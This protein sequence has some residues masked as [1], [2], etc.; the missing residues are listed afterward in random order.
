LENAG[1]GTYTLISKLGFPKTYRGKIM[2]VAFLGTHAPLLGAALYLLLGSSVSL[3]AALRIL[4]LL[5]AVTLLGAAATLVVLGALLA[6]VR[7]TSS[8]LKHYLDDRTKPDLPIGFSDEAGRLMADARYAVEHL[9][10]SIRSLEGLSGTD[11][12]SGLP[13]RREGEG[14]LVA[15]IA[16]T[17]RDGGRLTVAVVDL[18]GF[19]TIND[20]HGHHAGDVCIRQVADVIRRSVREGDWLARWGGDEF[21]LAL[22]D[23]SVFA[24]PEAVL[25]RINADLRRSPVRLLGGE[26]LVLG[27]SVGAHRY[28]GEDDLRELLAKA[29]AAMYQAN[30]EGRSWVLAD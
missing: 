19:K 24:S 16:R 18:D 12:L 9:D 7:L 30:R 29:D 21:V 4:A 17:R 11:Y 6:P 26:E 2:L 14:R 22:W 10:S 23:D 27:I 13:N 20:A 8:A 5:V 28:A 25:G 3:G 1:L 15:D